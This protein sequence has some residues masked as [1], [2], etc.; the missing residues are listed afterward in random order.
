MLLGLLGLS[1]FLELLGLLNIK[2]LW[3]WRILVLGLLVIRLI[4]LKK[5][6]IWAIRAI[7]HIRCCVISMC[8]L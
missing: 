6:L 7:S 3:L 1:E 8:V 5:L 2:H 4:G